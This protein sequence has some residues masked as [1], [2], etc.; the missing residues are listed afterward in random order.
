MLVKNKECLLWSNMIGALYPMLVKLYNHLHPVGDVAF[1]F[2][3]LGVDEDYALNIF[4]MTN[5]S[6]ETTKE[7]IT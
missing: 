2:A 3:D 1:G 6:A 5:N 7:I 4:Q